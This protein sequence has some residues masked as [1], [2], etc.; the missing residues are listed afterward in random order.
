MNEDNI[1]DKTKEE[2]KQFLFLQQKKTLITLLEHNAITQE[3]FEE[4]YSDM[5]KKMGYNRD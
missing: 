5:A 4:S 2:Q 1:Q 3:Q